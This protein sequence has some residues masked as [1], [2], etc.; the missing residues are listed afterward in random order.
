MNFT[1]NETCVENAKDAPGA[2]DLLE[3][4]SAEESASGD[5]SREFTVQ[6][7]SPLTKN[8]D[9]F[10]GAAYACEQNNSKA[11]ELDDELPLVR[12][13]S[14]ENIYV[15]TKLPGEEPLE[16]SEDVDI[17][18]P[19]DSFNGRHTE[20]HLAKQSDG[21]SCSFENLY[22]ESTAKETTCVEEKD[23]DEQEDE[24]NLDRPEKSIK[25]WQKEYDE[26]EDENASY[27][28]GGRMTLTFENESSALASSPIDITLESGLDK[29]GC[30]ASETQSP[31]QHSVSYDLD[32]N[33]DGKM[34]RRF[35]TGSTPDEIGA[36]SV[37]TEK[38]ADIVVKGIVDCINVTA[39]LVICYHSQCLGILFLI[40][41]SL[42]LHF[43]G[44]Y[45]DTPVLSLLILL[46]YKAHHATES[47]NCKPI[48]CP[49][50][51]CA[52][53]V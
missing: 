22:E 32:A 6:P 2:S 47:I 39:C 31:L 11:I 19:G 25:E 15:G 12:S 17:T 43:S 34:V 13:S 33:V 41:Q 38:N 5:M 45:A 26:M 27:T 16:Y 44:H 49:K 18:S 42:P 4:N 28:A 52:I 24:F 30:G 8:C 29:V 46:L 51:G 21:K 23:V 3:A 50:V 48:T 20:S 1:A 53:C 37:N 40:Q 35:S 10:V 9:G 36:V 14:Y 7:F